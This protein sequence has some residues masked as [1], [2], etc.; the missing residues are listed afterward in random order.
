VLLQVEGSKE[1]F[2]LS[3]GGKLYYANTYQKE[4]REGD[5]KE[6]SWTRT[7]D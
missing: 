7:E 3:I 2:L 5:G 6:G 4:I 1:S